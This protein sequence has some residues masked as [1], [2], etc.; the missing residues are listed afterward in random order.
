MSYNGRINVDGL[1]HDTAAGS[2]KV[3]DLESS[4]AV[5]KKTAIVTGT[6]SSSGTTVSVIDTG[7]RNSSGDE[8]N[9]T[10]VEAIVLKS[11]QAVE[12]TGTS[13]QLYTAA[14]LCSVTQ[15]PNQGSDSFVVIG[16]GSFFLLLIGD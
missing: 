9:F 4:Q 6:A 10:N 1:V 7:Y 11:D 14:G 2:I 5:T 8:V 13:L 3:V 16:A 12:I 15:T